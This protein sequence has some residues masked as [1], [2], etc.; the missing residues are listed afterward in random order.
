MYH[1][2]HVSLSKIIFVVFFSATVLISAPDDGARAAAAV[3]ESNLV[4]YTEIVQL[5]SRHSQNP[6]IPNSQTGG[7]TGGTGGGICPVNP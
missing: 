6:C 7:R 4:T 1:L 2:R 3:N 5:R